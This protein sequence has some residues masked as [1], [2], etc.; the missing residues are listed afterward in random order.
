MCIL[1]CLNFFW[2]WQIGTGSSYIT[3]FSFH[4]LCTLQILLYSEMQGLTLMC[5]FWGCCMS[6]CGNMNKHLF[7]PDRVPAIDQNNSTIVHCSV[8]WTNEFLGLFMSMGEALLRRKW[9]NQRLL[10]HWKAHSHMG[11]KSRRLCSW[12][13]RYNLLIAQLFGEYPAPHLLLLILPC[14]KSLV[15]HVYF[16]WFLR[17]L[18][19]LFLEHHKLHLLSES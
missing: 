7:T 14:G 1:V 6:F 16:G 3:S 12:S 9:M 18:N 19:F 13:S 5:E 4:Y 2:K 15:N 8:C 10:H 17:L 11:D